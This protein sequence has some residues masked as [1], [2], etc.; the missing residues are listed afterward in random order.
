MSQ[1]ENMIDL[2]QNFAHSHNFSESSRQVANTPTRQ[3][4]YRYACY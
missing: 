4:A 3:Q 1:T 2:Q